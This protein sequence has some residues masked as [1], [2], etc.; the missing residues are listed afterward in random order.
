MFR[1]GLEPG[2]KFG[3]MVMEEK[4][5]PDSMNKMYSNALCEQT[6]F[7]TILPWHSLLLT[8]Q[9]SWFSSNRHSLLRAYAFAWNVLP[10]ICKACFLSLSSFFS[11]VTFSGELNWLPYLKLS[12]SH[13]LSPCPVLF[14]SQHVL[15]PGTLYSLLPISCVYTL[16]K[17]AEDR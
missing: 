7:P 12:S 5:I 2:V 14:F 10:D 9:S 6:S 8:Y 17:R 4:S 1:L 13:S 3:Y 11:N 16:P 15:L